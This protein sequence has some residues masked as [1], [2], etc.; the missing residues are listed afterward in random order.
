MNK[1]DSIERNRHKQEIRGDIR[2]QMVC[3]TKGNNKSL[4]L[5]TLP[6]VNCLF[7]R[8]MAEYCKENN[9][10]LRLICVEKN[11]KLIELSK[12]NLPECALMLSGHLDKIITQS[13]NKGA[14]VKFDGIWVD[15]CSAPDPMYIFN[16]SKYIK[17]WLEDK[18]LIY[19]TF[20]IQGRGK[21]GLPSILNLLRGYHR[22]RP[23]DIDASL[24]TLDYVKEQIE[25]A[26]W[27]SFKEN[28]LS[29]IKKIYSVIYPGGDKEKTPM[30]T[31]GFSKGICSNNPEYVEPIIENRLAKIRKFKQEKKSDK[32]ASKND[33]ILAL[34][35]KGWSNKDIAE[36]CEISIQSI[37]A[38][39]AWK[40]KRE[41]GMPWKIKD[42]II[43]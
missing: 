36:H 10:A 19:V 23:I 5:C 9:I 3:L 27:S 4:R 28:N 39:K 21:Q 37:C 8:M 30:L 43:S 20:W 33:R 42:R 16:V 12:P 1:N 41:E 34:I 17:L 24:I 26:L 35:A 40:N 11:P 32:Y 15:L 25:A 22:D 38:T 6:G 29:N 2:S 31:I 14:F 7:E 13:I 18:G